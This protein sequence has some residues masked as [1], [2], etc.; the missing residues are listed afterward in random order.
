MVCQILS[1]EVCAVRF[2]KSGDFL[3]Q[4][5]AIKR[6]AVGFRNQLQ[7]VDLRRVAEDLPHARRAAFRR[8]AAAVQA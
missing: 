8:K 3:R 7:R 4:F 5:T 6:F 1:R 2:G